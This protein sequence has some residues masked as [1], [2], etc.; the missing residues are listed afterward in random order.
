MKGAIEQRTY[1]VGFLPVCH[2]EILEPIVGDN[3][4]SI[5]R[6]SCGS[7]VKVASSVEQTTGSSRSLEEME[8]IRRAPNK[9]LAQSSSYK[10]TGYST[11]KEEGI[12]E[13]WFPSVV[14]NCCEILERKTCPAPIIVLRCKNLMWG[15][16]CS[17]M[18]KN[19]WELVR[20][21]QV[22]KQERYQLPVKT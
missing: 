8:G 10:L 4:T 21:G 5:F 17:R 6:F 11:L 16:I 13:T 19:I 12:T 1:L 14:L 3:V 22:L 9:L 7:T 20:S 15:F 2:V 18:K